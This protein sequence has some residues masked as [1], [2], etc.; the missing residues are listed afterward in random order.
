LVVPLVAE[1]A[2]STLDLFDP[3]VRG[4][5]PG[6]GDLGADEDLDLG[7]PVR[8]RGGELIGLGHVSGGDRHFEVDPGVLGCWDVLG[9]QHGPQAL[10]D[11]P[12][13]CDLLEVGVGEDFFEPVQ[14]S[15]GE[16]VSGS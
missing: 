11:C 3:G 10:F 7:P 13:S 1:S 6:V 2:A 4:F 12:G 5:G 16:S 9:G 8:D 14:P 15:I